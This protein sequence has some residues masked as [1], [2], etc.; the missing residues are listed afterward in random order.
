MALKERTEV[1][2]QKIA[3]IGSGSWGTALSLLLV[4]KGYNTWLWGRPEDGTEETNQ[5]REN[6]RYLPGI[7]LPPQLM[8]TCDEAEALFSSTAVIM[9]VPAQ[10]MR[11]VVSRLRSHL[12]ADAII[13]SAAKGIEQE[14]LLRM[15]E[16]LE[17]E[18]PSANQ[19]RTAVIS[20]PSHAEEVARF[21]P[22][23]VVASSKNKE[24][25]LLVQELLMNSRFRV[26]TN[27][28]LVGVET[29]GALKNIIALAAGISDGL[30]Y[31][32][33]TRAALITRGLTEMKR[34]GLAMG[35][36]SETFFGLS[37]LGDL[38]VT[39]NSLHSRNRR[40][41]ILLG[42]GFSRN[43]VTQRINMVVEGIETA[44]AVKELA[45]NL[46]VEMPITAQVWEV[47]CAGLSPRTAVDKLMLRSRKLEEESLDWPEEG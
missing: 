3:V 41:G 18:L 32:D 42:Q 36:K 5:Y 27:S 6:K 12:P 9:A 34:L 43:D 15:S 39:C 24:T 38:I 26:Y 14:T 21:I 35:S 17:Q 2:K 33:N 31:G 13:I 46:N 22:T 11:A 19:K 8:I 40:A 45:S 4:H 23:A 37:G 47:L 25:A 7:D 30:G 1:I 10:A 20:G 29:G 28:D 16:V 44:L